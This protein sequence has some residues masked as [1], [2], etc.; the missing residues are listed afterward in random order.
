MKIVAYKRLYGFTILTE[1]RQRTCVYLFHVVIRLYHLCK[2]VVGPFR[3][4]SNFFQLRQTFQNCRLRQSVAVVV[5]TWWDWIKNTEKTTR[6]N[7][8][9]WLWTSI[10]GNM[11]QG[12]CSF[13]FALTRAFRA[14]NR[15]EFR[16]LMK[17]QAGANLLRVWAPEPVSGSGPGAPST[18]DHSSYW[19][20]PASALPEKDQ[21]LWIESSFPGMFDAFWVFFF[22]QHGQDAD[23]GLLPQKHGFTPWDQIDASSNTTTAAVRLRDKQTEECRFV[24]IRAPPAS[25]V[26]SSYPVVDGRFLL[27]IFN[28]QTRLK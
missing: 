15:R 1:H 7:G 14:W 17:P 13:F 21:N 16:P 8:T 28:I 20:T 26:D 23:C 24:L 4:N 27:D 25:L 18:A 11:L 3:G 19:T 2:I 22:F 9:W 6:S 10:Q 5:K 12:I